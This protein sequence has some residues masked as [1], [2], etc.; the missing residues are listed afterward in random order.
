MYKSCLCDKKYKKVDD[1]DINFLK[2]TL[3]PDRVFVKDQI[4]EDYCHD[5]LN[6]IRLTLKF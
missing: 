6:T 1:N 2:Q 4:K 5:E 3:D